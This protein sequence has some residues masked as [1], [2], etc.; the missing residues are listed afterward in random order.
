M[1]ALAATAALLEDGLLGVAIRP[2][3]VPPG[4][5]A[6]STVSVVD[7]TTKLGG[8]IVLNGLAYHGEP[9]AGVGGS[10]GASGIKNTGPYPPVVNKA[11]QYTIHWL[12]TNYATDANNVTIS[13]YLQSGTSCTGADKVPASTT[14]SCDSTSGA[15]SW[16]IPVVPATTGITGKPLEAVFQVKNTPAINQLG[17]DVTLVGPVSLAAT[18]AFTSST[19]QASI[20]PVTTALPNDTSVNPNA[21]QVTQ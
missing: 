3:T 19:M 20:A 8:N 12:I 15:V 9:T 2:P 1:R 5:A 17:Q 16:Q 21:R 13:A 14:F 6:S 7:L 18:D 11:S 4:T 10:M